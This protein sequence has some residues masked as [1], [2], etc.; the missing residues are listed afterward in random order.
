MRPRLTQAN[1]V[2]T[3]L[4]LLV[5]CISNDEYLLLTVSAE[6]IRSTAGL[7]VCAAHMRAT[8][9]ALWR[10]VSTAYSA[11]LSKW[12]FGRSSSK[13][14]TMICTQQGALRVV[15]GQHRAAGVAGGSPRL[16]VQ[17][18]VSVTYLKLV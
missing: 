18:T 1:Y 8:S 11:A 4:L 6:M 3:L 12:C 13:V 17:H 15:L 2:H 5:L 7:P 10:A 16:Q 14:L 9:S